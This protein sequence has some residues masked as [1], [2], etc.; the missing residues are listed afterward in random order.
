MTNKFSFY[1]LHTLFLVLYIANG[2]KFKSCS[3]SGFCQ[4]QKTS[5]LQLNSGYYL[6]A[7]QIQIKNNVFEAVMLNKAS[8][9]DDSKKLKLSLS[10]VVN[11][12]LRIFVTELNPIRSRFDAEDIMTEKAR[13]FLKLTNVEQSVNEC[14]LSWNDKYSINI[15]YQPFKIVIT[16]DGVAE[17]IINEFDT[18]YFEIYRNRSNKEEKEEEDDEE[19]DESKSW[20][21]SFS[22]HTYHYDHGPASIGLDFTFVNSKHVYGIPEHASSLALK[23]YSEPYRLW[24]LDVFEYKLDV[25]DALY[26]A[27]PY[28]LGYNLNSANAVLWM[29]TAET[30]VDI[31]NQNNVRW[32]SESGAMEAFVLLY[33]NNAENEKNYL[34][35]YYQITGYPQ[36]PPMFALG[37]HQ[38]RWNYNDINEVKQISDK[39]DELD[40]PTDVIWL[41]IEHTDGKRYFTWNKYNFADP[42]HMLNYVSSSGRKMVNIVDPHIKKDENYYIYSEMDAL[43]VWVKNRDGDAYTGWCWPGDSRYPDFINPTTRRYWSQ[44]FVESKYIH[45]TKD[46]FIW[47][48][49]NE[50]SVFNGPEVSMPISNIHTLSDGREVRH[51]EVHNIYG[52]YVHKA[53]FDGLLLRSGGELRPFV[54]SR[55][56]FAGSQQF[57][58]VWTGDNTANWE[59]L[60]MSVPMLLSL[61][62]SGLPFVGA[63]IGGFFNNPDGELMARWYELGA[64]YPFFRNHA[65]QDTDRRELWQFDQEYAQRMKLAI[66]ARYRILPYLYTLFYLNELILRPLWY[67]EFRKDETSYDREDAFMFGNAF[68]VCPIV[69]AGVTEVDVELPQNKDGNAIFYENT[70]S[71]INIY[72]AAAGKQHLVGYGSRI[73]VLRYGGSITVEK[74]RI[75]RSAS[76][77]KYDP[78]TIII[79][80][81]AANNAMGYHYIDDEESVNS[82]SILTT[83]KY[84]KHTL[85][86]DIKHQSKTTDILPQIQIERIVIMAKDIHK[87]NFHQIQIKQLTNSRTTKQFGVTQHTLAIRKPQIRIN[88]PFTLQL[89]I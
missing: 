33:D 18:F 7:N 37:H 44:Q 82:E 47:N 38:C 49:M 11:D 53:T 40:V 26:G 73:P 76:L 35:Q 23:S 29:N 60:A 72:E 70:F 57:G 31:N 45:S 65:H 67:G 21:E 2:S 5:N 13:K 52:Y 30:Y 6:D 34:D 46:L 58:A 71:N 28:I 15:T 1:I 27:I 62:I 80:L 51:N 75:R 24:N 9:T 69:E 39:L 68:Y 25:P 88:V 42:P 61:S 78:V 86:N 22:S 83:L 50:P 56:F 8:A 66:L 4:R 55:S 36:L 89:S 41:D 77:M 16:K 14:I 74:H 3:S 63:D 12:V 87:M 10:R 17:M 59:H 85:T 20:E 43:D 64:Y 32:M 48:D 81:D 54:L 84:E 19:D 79:A